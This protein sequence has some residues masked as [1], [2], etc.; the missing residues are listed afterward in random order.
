MKK[1]L[2]LTAVLALSLA[3][4]IGV[5]AEE[6]YSVDALYINNNVYNSGEYEFGGGQPG[7][8]GEAFKSEVCITE[9][10]KMYILG[11]FASTESNVDR[12][13][14]RIDG[15]VEYDCQDNYRDRC[16]IYDY[17]SILPWV[18]ECGFE[19]TDFVKSGFGKDQ[20]MMELTGIGDLPVGEYD[21]EIVGKFQD[22]EEMILRAYY[23]YI[24][25]KPITIRDFNAETDKQY[26]DQILI[27]G[28][29]KANG[30]DAVAALKALVDGSDG[31]VNTITMFGWFGIV[32]AET[33]FGDVLDS[34][35]Y[36]IDDGTPVFDKAFA[37]DTE[38]AVSES[39][40]VRYKTTVDVS[41]LQ[42]GETHVITA[43]VKLKSGDVVLFNREDREAIINYKAPLAATEVPVQETPEADPTDNPGDA[44]SEPTEP[45]EKPVSPT[46]A[47]NDGSAS[48]SGSNSGKKG[49][50][51]I[52]GGGFAL[53]AA[54]ACV[55]AI[56][57]KH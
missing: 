3:L 30:N 36:I 40:G 8:E 18:E 6:R 46:D 31:T 52:I 34:F 51:G 45:T 53:V 33:A 55:L 5:F 15:D 50:G 41:G 38:P 10:D 25:E 22:G 19:R 28:E 20:E 48:D 26:F 47:P 7:T 9:G 21:L 57:K 32:D 35:G 24:E 49:C 13:V 29:E 4:C 54:A 39:N 11:W 37:V 1:I 23:L 43:C 56:R 12:L 14:Y 44:T 17:A 2:V 42:D 16:E 27:N